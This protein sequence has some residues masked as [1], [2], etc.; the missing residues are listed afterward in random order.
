MA[1]VTLNNNQVATIINLAKAQSTG[2]DEIQTLDLEGIIDAGNDQTIIGSVEQ[3]TKAIINVCNKLWFTDSSYRSTYEDPFYVDSEVYGAITQH[4]SMELPGAQESHAWREITSGVSTAGEYTLFL[5]VVHNQF[6]GKTNSWEVPIAIT[7]E[8]WN[9]AF[10]SE[11]E[12]RSFVSYIMMC[13]DNAIVVHLKDMDRANRNNFIAEKFDYAASDDAH[14]V[15]V[16]NLVEAWANHIGSTENITV[17]DFRTN[18]NALNWVASQFKLYATKLREMS[19]IFNTAGYDKFVPS[20][21]L[22]IQILADFESDIDSAAQSDTYHNNVVALPGH[23]S[24]AFW[25]GAG[26]DFSWESVSSIDVKTGAAGSAVNK[27]GIV[28]LMVDKY[29]IMHTIWSRRVA[30]KVF[31]PEDI[32][33]YY[34]QFRDGYY[35]NLTLPGIVFYLADYTAE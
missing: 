11:S 24:I 6:Y 2:S 1:V 16:V 20:D 28:A 7:G 21:R 35:N 18:R 8:Q 14:G 4:I 10:R 29:A 13:V 15:H 26:L 19:S 17:K 31:E 22:I 3:F 12:L 30:A 5:P 27:T 25:Q 34:N 9:T 32:T 33:Q 23:Q